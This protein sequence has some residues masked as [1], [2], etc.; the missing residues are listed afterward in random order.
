MQYWPGTI[1]RNH[2]FRTARHDPHSDLTQV[3][4]A[5]TAW[6]RWSPSESIRSNAPIQIPGAP[7][8]IPAA[9]KTIAGAVSGDP[10]VEHPEIPPLNIQGLGLDLTDPKALGILA[11]M[12]VSRDPVALQNVIHERLPDAK[13]TNDAQGNTMVQ[14]PGGPQMY[15]DR[16]GLTPQ[17]ALFFGPQTAATAVSGGSSVIGVG[18]RQAIQHALDQLSSW[19]L[20]GADSPIDLKGTAIAAALP[21]ALG[22]L[23]VAGIKGADWLMANPGAHTAEEIAARARALSAWGFSGKEGDITADPGTLV[24]RTG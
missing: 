20:G 16:P 2:L 24:Q 3:P 8:S 15:V 23:G 12:V 13:F 14:V 22:G 10:Y 1:T 9:A 18:V 6:R 5:L 17:K 21:M 11:H 7:A 19:G 4:S